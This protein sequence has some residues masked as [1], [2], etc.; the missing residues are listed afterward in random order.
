MSNTHSILDLS[1]I[2]AY[3]IFRSLLKGWSFLC[4]YHKLLER[5]LGFLFLTKR[6]TILLFVFQIKL[7]KL[8]RVLIVERKLGLRSER[9]VTLLRLLLLLL[10]FSLYVLE[11]VIVATYLLR[12]E[13]RYFGAERD[14]LIQILMIFSQSLLKTLF[15]KVI[16]TL[17]AFVWGRCHLVESHI[18]EVNCRLVN[19]LICNSKWLNLFFRF[20]LVY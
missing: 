13:H 1:Y 3:F 15:E 9:R 7:L 19:K 4:I 2:V 6:R 10:I 8:W 11:A 16:L 5:R 20:N 17:A 18:F 14:A 12:H